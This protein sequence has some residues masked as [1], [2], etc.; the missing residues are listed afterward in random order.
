MKVIIVGK[1]EFAGKVASEING[2]IFVELE[3]RVFPDGEVCPRL[4]I[5]DKDIFKNSHVIIALQLNFKQSKNE[6]LVSLLLTIYN[7][8]RHGAAKITCILPY[9]IYSRQDRES[10]AG[11]PFSS[12]YLAMMLEAAGMNQFITIN[13][14]SYGKNPLSDFFQESRSKSLSAI[15]LI[16]KKI[17][18][19]SNSEDEILCFSPDEGALMLAKEAALAIESPFYGAI[20]KQRNPE[21]G[22]ITQDLVGIDIPLENRHILLIDD[23]VSSGGTMVGATRIFKQQGAKRV[24]LG[25]VHPVHS[26]EN[27]QKLQEEDIQ[28]F[29]TTNTIKLDYPGLTTVS[30]V[31]LI[32]DW[33]ISNSS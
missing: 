16:A 23:L 4:L 7:S 33:I 2:A 25:Y 22:E 8:K 27:F 30:V 9:H 31:K 29:V 32:A 12:K 3:E 24:Y 28:L 11:E 26:L 1:Q 18:E 10:R 15:P 17:Q 19:L 13:S 21:T 5:S 20:R 14:H 6:Y